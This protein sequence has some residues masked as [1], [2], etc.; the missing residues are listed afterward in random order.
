MLVSPKMRWI[1]EKNRNSFAIAGLKSAKR[2]GVYLESKFSDKT[3]GNRFLLVPATNDR[4][5]F[6]CHLV[7]PQAFA[8]E[9]AVYWKRFLLVPRRNDKA[10]SRLGGNLGGEAAPI[11]PIP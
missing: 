9:R 8:R 7:S 10:I 1:L 6:S 4:F 11:P 2:L 3:V 5:Q